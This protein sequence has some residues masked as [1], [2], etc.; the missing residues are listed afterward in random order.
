MIEDLLD[1]SAALAS[2]AQA[3]DARPSSK[4]PDA[5]DEAG[6]QDKDDKFGDFFSMFKV[7]KLW[8]DE[9]APEP[10]AAA[11]PSNVF[12]KAVLGPASAQCHFATC[13]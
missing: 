12:W 10:V 1:R 7:A 8:N 2:R 5:P 9:P 4:A 11:V 13:S 6:E 3:V